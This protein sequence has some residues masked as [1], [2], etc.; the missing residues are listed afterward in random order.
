MLET[1]QRN[2]V[3]RLFLSTRSSRDWHGGAEMTI[4]C[5][6]VR[7]RL[8]D[9]TNSNLMDIAGFFGQAHLESKGMAGQK[10]DVR[11]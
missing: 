11:R 2:G 10:A 3:E 1:S 5:N 4:Y 9:P 6:N 8:T 7:H